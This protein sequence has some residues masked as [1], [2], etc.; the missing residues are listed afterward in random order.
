MRTYIK[1][2]NEFLSETGSFLKFEY[3]GLSSPDWARNG[4]KHDYYS[5][6]LGRKGERL[7]LPFYDSEHNTKN[8][9][10]KTISAYDILCHLGYEVEEN[11][12]DFLNE[13]GYE[14]TGEREYLRLKNIH[15]DLIDQYRQLRKMYNE[16]ELELLREIC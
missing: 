9:R 10:K 7:T 12:D 2:A 4:F 16:D 15:L 11:F 6:T 14:I 1:Q 5:V 8:K 13:F 3:I